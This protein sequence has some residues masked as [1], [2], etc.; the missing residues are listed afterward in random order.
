[1]QQFDNIA[2][3]E[4]FRKYYHKMFFYARR[5]VGES[6][7]EDVVLNAFVELW[8][9]FDKIDHED[10]VEYYL[11]KVVY[12]RAINQLKVNR[13]MSAT[14]VE[15]INE[16]CL[17]YYQSKL[18]DGDNNLENKDLKAQID[19]AINELPEKCREVFVLS[20]LHDMKNCEIAQ[21][22]DI[23]VR[24]VEAHMYKA[25]KY[26]RSRLGNLAIYLLLFYYFMTKCF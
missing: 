3:R 26:L 12:T 18:G 25:L 13:R 17:E 14:L 15:D 20:Y 23:S 16:A 4:L 8:K 24:T 22:M 10:L 6:D 7:A 5:I 9:R 2:Y 19:Q 11:Y 21:A 1:M